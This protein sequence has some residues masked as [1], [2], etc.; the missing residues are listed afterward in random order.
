MGQGTFG[1]TLLAIEHNLVLPVCADYQ[2]TF[3]LVC[4]VF[5]RASGA[6]I[7]VTAAAGN[8]AMDVRGKG[9]AERPEPSHSI[10]SRSC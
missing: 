3:D 6:G 1:C 2:A 9:N 4:E 10:A 7:M 5:K 8:Y